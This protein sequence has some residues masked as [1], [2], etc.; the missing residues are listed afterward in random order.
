MRVI[1]QGNVFVC[2]RLIHRGDTA[3]LTDA[4]GQQEAAFAY[5]AFG[6]LHS[7]ANAEVAAHRFSGKEWDA[8]A[9]LY[10]FGFRWY[11]PDTGTWTAKDPLGFGG[12]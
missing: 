8:D 3:F 12:G 11:D 9:Q 1:S 2:C 6:R 4:D 10:Y 7:S 5:D